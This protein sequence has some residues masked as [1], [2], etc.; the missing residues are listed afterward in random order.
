MS[1]KRGE[2]TKL[3][4]FVCFSFWSRF[5]CQLPNEAVS[6]GMTLR[7]GSS[8]PLHT[9]SAL[10]VLRQLRY[11]QDHPPKSCAAGCSLTCKPECEPAELRQK[12]LGQ[13]SQSSCFAALQLHARP[14]SHPRKR[15]DPLPT[16]TPTPHRE[17]GEGREQVIH[18]M[19]R[20]NKYMKNDHSH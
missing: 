6:M 13:W 11:L 3:V 2:L 7:Y 8:C 1:Y 4:C 18:K 19:R 12:R 10:K 14:R 5:S 9:P 16:P 17:T 20:A 15:R